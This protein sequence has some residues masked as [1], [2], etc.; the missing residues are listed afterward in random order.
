MAVVNYD[1]LC[2]NDVMSVV[3]LVLI[4]LLAPAGG[5]VCVKC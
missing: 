1:Y 5:T 4:G 2:I 3:R